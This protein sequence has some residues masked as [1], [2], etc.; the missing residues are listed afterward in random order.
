MSETK[1]IVWAARKPNGTLTKHHDG[2]VCIW[3]DKRVATLVAGHDG[4]PQ[5]A[6]LVVPAE[7]AKRAGRVTS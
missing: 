6:T 5:K 3:K 4:W 2:T 7:R 1:F